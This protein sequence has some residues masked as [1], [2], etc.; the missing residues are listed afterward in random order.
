M[1]AAMWRRAGGLAALGCALSVAASAQAPRDS[2]G[3][4]TPPRLSFPPLSATGRSSGSSRASADS[5]RTAAVA[6][7]PILLRPDE[8]AGLIAIDTPWRV[9]AAPVP[10]GWRGLRE[11]G[12]S[13]RSGRLSIGDMAWRDPLGDA[14]DLGSLPA[15]PCWFDAEGS[16]TRGV[17]GLSPAVPARTL[18]GYDMASD[19]GTVLRAGLGARLLGDA[20]LVGW[21]NAVDVDRRDRGG[22]RV[23]GRAEALRVSRRSGTDGRVSVTVVSLPSTRERSATVA[24]GLGTS[25]VGTVVQRHPRIGEIAWTRGHDAGDS[26][27]L[28]L[29]WSADRATVTGSLDALT[30]TETLRGGALAVDARGATAAGLWAEGGVRREGLTY[31]GTAFGGTGGDATVVLADST[32]HRVGGDLTA[33]VRRTF[34]AAGQVRL[35]VHMAMPGDGRAFVAPV[36]AL[37]GGRT[38]TWRVSLDPVV[39]APSLWEPLRRIDDTAPLG[40]LPVE[41]GRVARAGLGWRG[42]HG[43][44]HVEAFDAR[45]RGV[46]LRAA[47]PF[48]AEFAVRRA[49][50]RVQLWGAVARADLDVTSAWT[51]RC[52]SAWTASPESV[53]TEAETP[54]WASSAVTTWT[55]RCLGVDCAA[56]TALVLASRTPSVVAA[57]AVPATAV[58]DAALALHLQGAWCV[59]R[60]ENLAGRAVGPASAPFSTTPRLLAGLLLSLRD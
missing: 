58:W 55:G 32:R 17:V 51:L 48:D 27:R 10:G 1:T 42:T 56:S 24:D 40:R 25:T 2:S 41:H 29:A 59:I 8:A 16:P 50:G 15:W 7:D 22:P 18:L 20:A 46:G 4:R 44:L 30:W 12:A 45:I 9:S 31:R 52:G 49:T 28:A 26:L 3:V 21:V 37:D 14:P 53:R 5:T 39:T 43:G 33:G 36:A 54:R 13:P 6:P 34:G 23:S 19:G 35:G 11:W 47:P 57:N 60:G 38:V